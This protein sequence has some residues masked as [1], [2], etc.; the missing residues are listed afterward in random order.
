MAS[1]KSNKISARTVAKVTKHHYR[2][3]FMEMTDIA[4]TQ[5]S[6]M[7]EDDDDDDGDDVNDDDEGGEEID[8]KGG[9]LDRMNDLAFTK[10]RFQVDETESDCSTGSESDSDEANTNYDARRDSTVIE[11]SQSARQMSTLRSL[12]PANAILT[13]D[14]DI[15]CSLT[16]LKTSKVLSMSRL[17]FAKDKGAHMCR[18]KRQ[19]E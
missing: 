10:Y 17:T 8:L 7:S 6:P 13:L 9:M 18:K 15:N 19:I 12:L 1:S 16:L 11:I 5:A 2:P 4:D 3:I 14:L